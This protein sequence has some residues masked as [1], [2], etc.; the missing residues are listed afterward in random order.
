MV[1]LGTHFKIPGVGFWHDLGW[2]G[3]FFYTDVGI[4]VLV[5]FDLVDAAMSL[6][7]RKEMTKYLYHHQEALWNKIFSSY[8]DESLM[9]KMIID[10]WEKQL[11]T[12]R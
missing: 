7:K 10:N 2:V 8:F 11:I 1:R 5:S 4:D 9:E 3:D 6:V 12:L